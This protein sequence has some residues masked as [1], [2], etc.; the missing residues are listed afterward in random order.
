MKTPYKRDP[1]LHNTKVSDQVRYTWKSDIEEAYKRDQYI[2][3][4]TN[5]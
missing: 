1:G 3:K 4:E 5:T 2:V